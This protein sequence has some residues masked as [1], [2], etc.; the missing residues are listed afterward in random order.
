MKK[1]VTILV[2]CVFVLV[3]LGL[4]LKSVSRQKENPSPS[5]SATNTAEPSSEAGQEATAKPTATPNEKIRY[6]EGRVLDTEKPSVEGPVAS[7]TEEE[8]SVS[9][10]GKAYVFRLGENGKR[11]IAYFNQNPEQPRIMEGTIIIVN[12][13]NVGK[14]KVV[15]SLEIVESN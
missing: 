8:I 14:D 6:T 13:E 9:I 12:Y 1:R 4:G 5:A 10:S 11:D 2:I 3:L 15:S 7:L